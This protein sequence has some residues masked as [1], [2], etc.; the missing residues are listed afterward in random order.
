MILRP[1]EGIFKGEH[2][3]IKGLKVTSGEYAGLFGYIRGATIADVTL[4]GGSIST[5][6]K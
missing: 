5:T 4:T 2:Y 1:Y 3:T 6:G